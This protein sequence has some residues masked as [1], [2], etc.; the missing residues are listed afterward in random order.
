MNLLIQ[1][2]VVHFSQKQ[3]LTKLVNIIKAIGIGIMALLFIAVLPTIIAAVFSIATIAVA[4]FI[5]Y[6]AYLFFQ[7][8]SNGYSS[9]QINRET[10]R[11]RSKR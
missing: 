8:E 10:E 6:V 3:M 9:I 1:K 7:D 4:G 2:V 5:A 11:E